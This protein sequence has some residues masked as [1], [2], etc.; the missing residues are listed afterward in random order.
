M[1]I[2]FRVGWESV[3]RER[4]VF[5]YTLFRVPFGGGED[6]CLPY[7]ILCLA[8]CNF[9]CCMGREGSYL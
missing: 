3:G 9:N 1:I 2:M 4:Q 5:N 8:V 7:Y 6:V